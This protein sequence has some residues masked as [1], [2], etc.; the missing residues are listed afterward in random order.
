[1]THRGWIVASVYLGFT[2][3]TLPAQGTEPTAAERGKKALLERAFSPVTWPTS[4]YEQVWRQWPRVSGEKPANFAAIFQDRY[5]LPPAP[6]PNNEYPMGL[7]LT[8]GLFGSG[9]TSD[10]MLCHG[11]SIAGQ[12]YVGLGNASLDMQALYE[13]LFKASGISYR[14]PFTIS[15]VRGTSEA[16]AMSVYLHAYREPDLSLRSQPLDL[17]L[18]DD[19]CEDPPAWWLLKKK[20]TMYHTGSSNARSVRSIMQF[21]LSPTNT[22]ATFQKEEATFRDILAFLL[23]IE[24]PKYPFPIDTELAHQGERVFVATCAKCHGTYGKDWT[25]PNKIVPIDVIGTDRTRWAGLSERLR[26]HY[27]QSWFA[28]EKSGWLAD[29]YPARQTAGYQAPPLDGI[30]ATAPYLHNGSVPAVYY[31]LNSKTR[32]KYFTRTFR[33]DKDAYDPVKL[34]WKVRVL[35]HGVDPQLPARERRQVY[36][37]TLPGRGNGGHPFGDALSEEERMAVIEYL[38]TL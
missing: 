29:D 19:L 30:W 7:R 28:H 27:N 1:M 33:T 8:R 6:Y 31:L 21:M 24:P 13:D 14:A 2:L 26:R 37:T 20:K 5:G 15:N 34:G 22:A 32:P 16:G 10:C 36:D 23:S 3:G 38:K 18:R 9:L 25:Y 4:A 12:S 35:E 17:R 11:G